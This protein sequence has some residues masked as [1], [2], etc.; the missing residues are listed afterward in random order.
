MSTDP[1]AWIATRFSRRRERGPIVTVEEHTVLWRPRQRRGGSGGAIASGADAADRRPGRVCAHR[2]RRPSCSIIS[3][4]RRGHSRRRARELREASDRCRTQTHPRHRSGHDEHQG[5]PVRR[6]GASGRGRRGR[7]PITFPQPGWVEQ[8]ARA[9]WRSVEDGDR[10][11]PRRR[12]RLRRSRRR[13]HQSARVRAASGNARTGEPVGPCI[14]WQCRRTTASATNCADAACKPRS[15]DDAPGSRSTR[16][17]RPARCAG[18]LTRSRTA[19]LARAR[20]SSASGT[21]DSWLLWNLTGGPPRVRCHATL[22]ARSCLNLQLVRL[23]SRNCSSIFAFP[24]PSCPRCGHPAAIFGE[25]TAIP[26][27]P[28][29]CRSPA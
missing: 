20:A 5:V 14:V 19:W 9:I 17:S 11:L 4:S 10:R 15:R 27:L 16:C 8:D 1:S 18:C 12:R 24:P 26:A 22:R 3:A 23:G 7:S 6:A 25:V 29:A 28:A 13:R 21:V 2:D